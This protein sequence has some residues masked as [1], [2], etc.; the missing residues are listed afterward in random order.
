MLSHVWLQDVYD[1]V[2]RGSGCPYCANRRVSPD[3]SL[4]AVHPRVALEWH[5]T[6]N[7]ALTPDM[8][9]AGGG[10][11]VRAWFQCPKDPTHVFRA[12]V[13]NRA[14]LSAGCPRCCGRSEFPEAGT[15]TVMLPFFVPC[16][17]PFNARTPDNVPAK[18]TRQALWT[19][20][21]S[22]WWLTPRS[23]LRRWRTL[24]RT[25]PNAAEV[26]TP[27]A[28]LRVLLKNRPRAPV[29]SSVEDSSFL[30]DDLDVDLEA[31]VSEIEEAANEIEEVASEIEE[32]A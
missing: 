14:K 13:C 9:S 30:L 17:S 31:L 28:V 15:V 5:P 25:Q 11:R 2:Q 24:L 20:G 26:F 19:D 23:L 29:E 3:T 10:K 32:A 6:L 18:S 21:E 8:V 7:G 16:W 1:R 12:L 27:Q 22:E 4:A